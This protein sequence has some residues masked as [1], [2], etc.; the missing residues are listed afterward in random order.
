VAYVLFTALLGTAFYMLY[1]T[2]AGQLVSERDQALRSQQAALVEVATARKTV[3]E[4]QA[5]EQK[6]L[7][8][9]SLLASGKREEFIARYTE[10]A[11]GKFTPVEQQVFQKGVERARDEIVDA[12]HAEGLEAYQGQQWKRAAASFKKGLSY[13]EAGPRAAQMRYYLGVASGKLGD[14]A[15]ASRQLELAIAGGA[16]RSVGSDARW[17]LGLAF[18]QLRQFDKAKAEFDRFAATRGLHPYAGAARRKSAEMAL[19][20]RPVP[21]RPVAAPPATP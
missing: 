16:E 4:R 9:W 19:K 15:E 18:E 2:R 11:Q 12:S 8:Y 21:A 17:H 10:I 1:R 14:Y 3:E 7:E 13:E 20:L 6:A 5:A